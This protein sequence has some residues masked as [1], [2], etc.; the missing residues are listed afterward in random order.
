MR[1]RDPAYTK[2]LLV[3]L[4]E[5][6]PVLEAAQL[7]ADLRRAGIE[8]FA[9]VINASLAAAGPRDPVLVQRAQP[10]S[11]KSRG[12][13]TLRSSSGDRAVVTRRTHGS[14]TLVSASPRGT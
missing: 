1:L 9:W 14:G 10:N 2:I 4:P 3:T 12:A 8:P 6:T 11:N 7:Q 13:R 5:P